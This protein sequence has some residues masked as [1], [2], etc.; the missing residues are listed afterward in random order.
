MDIDGTGRDFFGGYQSCSDW[1][2]NRLHACWCRD[3]VLAPAAT[4][5]LPVPWSTYLCNH[6]I[7]VLLVWT[8]ILWTDYLPSNTTTR[9]PLGREVLQGFAP[10]ESP[11][12]V[13][14]G[15]RFLHP[16]RAAVS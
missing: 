16:R 3:N 9:P 5:I 14:G 15:R 12:N 13:R 4:T 6:G 11:G 10:A 7:I 8:F 1:R 2:T